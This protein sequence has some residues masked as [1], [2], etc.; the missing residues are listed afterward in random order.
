MHYGIA[1][2]L[3]RQRLQTLQ[4]AYAAQPLRFKGRAPQPPALP[5]AAW[6]NPPQK[7]TAIPKIINIRSLNSDLRAA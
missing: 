1:E 2:T 3:H 5:A 4:L 6:I 7:E